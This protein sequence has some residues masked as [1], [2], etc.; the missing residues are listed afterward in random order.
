[1]HPASTPGPLCSTTLSDSTS[2]SPCPLTPAAPALLSSGSV[3]TLH[4]PAA[5]GSTSPRPSCPLAACAHSVTVLLAQQEQTPVFR[6]RT[7]FPQCRGCSSPCGGTGVGRD[8]SC[9][10]VVSRPQKGPGMTC[11]WRWLSAME[12]ALLRASVGTRIGLRVRLV[13]FQA[14]RNESTRPA[15]ACAQMRT[16]A[17][18]GASPGSRAWS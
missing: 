4:S 2:I 13:P 12:M 6:S 11:L 15:G 18:S 3:P 5:V 10:G 7:A 9:R 17:H 14:R 1:M 16:D 8:V